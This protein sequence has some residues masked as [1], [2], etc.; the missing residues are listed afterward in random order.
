MK[1]NHRVLLVLGIFRSGTSA[2]TKG[3][4]SLGA[5]LGDS[6]LP[7]NAFNEKGHWEDIQFHDFNVSMIASLEGRRRLIL[8]LT[9]E[10]VILL[11]EKGFFSQAVALLRKKI[12]VSSISSVSRVLTMKDPRFSLLLPFWKKVFEHCNVTPSFVISLR[13]P[14]GVVASTTYRHKSFKREHE[15][16][17]FWRWCSYL[18]SCLEFSQGY[19]R[20][21]VNYNEL[22]KNPA[23]QMKRIAHA[24]KLTVNQEAVQRYH[25]DFI[26]PSLCHFQAN[27]NNACVS[28]FYQQFAME[29]YEALLLIAK[30]QSTF[31]A[32]NI[33]LPQWQKQFVRAYSLLVLAEKNDWTVEDLKQTMMKHQNVLLECNKTINKKKHSIATLCQTLHQRNLQLSSLVQEQAKKDLEILQL[34]QQL[35]P[36]ESTRKLSQAWKTINALS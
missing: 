10:E 23:H 16:K 4:E 36:R 31:E 18:L 22:L 15:E 11:S 33:L 24:L 6:L 35:Q 8:P 14:R 1:K 26:D 9:Q 32:L 3:L 2:L 7:A 17:L 5:F 20:I 13:D 27:Q 21:L 34:K 25:D 30:D 19:E 29:I 12:S 28:S